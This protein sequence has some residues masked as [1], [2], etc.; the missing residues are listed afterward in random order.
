MNLLNKLY[1][2]FWSIVERSDEKRMQKQIFPESVGV[3]RDI[4]YVG[5]GKRAHL[6]DVYFPENRAEEKLPVIIDVHGGG[7]MYGYK[8][9]NENFCRRLA[10]RGFA[11][12]SVSYS[13]CPENPFPACLLDVTQALGYLGENLDSYPADREKVFIAGDSAGGLL[14]AY[15]CLLSTSGKLREIYGA[16]E[17]NLDIKAAGLI[18]GMFFFEDGLAK[19]LSPGIFGKGGR[20][21]S[22]YRDY[23][24]FYD[25]IDEGKFPPA[26]L[27]T[28]K[29]DMIR[30]STLKFKKL[31]DEKG[32]ESVFFDYP[33]GKNH[34]LEHVFSVLYPSEYPESTEVIDEMTAFFLNRCRPAAPDKRS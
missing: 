34:K 5:D 15:A 30:K 29:E 25:I 10:E 19:L 20:G 2:R 23:L 7:L 33:K 8:E 21:K 18:S 3:F 26:Y 11:V 17:T 12:V 13:L 31:L 9:L 24:S 16:K 32:V 27:V 14:A 6:L 22:A 4:P 1:K 28:S